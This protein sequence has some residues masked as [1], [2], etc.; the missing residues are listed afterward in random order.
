MRLKAVL[1]VLLLAFPASASAADCGL[2]LV[3]AVP[4]TMTPNG[5]RAL[6]PV[7]INGTPLTF[8]LDTGGAAT[9]IGA[10]AAQ[11]LKLPVTESGVKMLDLYGHASTKA[12]RVKTFGLGRLVDRDTE[13]PILP[14]ADFGKDRPY[15]ACCRRITWPNMTWSSISPAAS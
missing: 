2:K 9:Q 6:V 15:S 13:L 12:V 8:L 10:T 4:L 14:D 11:Q 7:T 5:L 1:G 3:N